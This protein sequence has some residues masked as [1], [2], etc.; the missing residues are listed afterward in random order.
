MK[1]IAQF[2]MITALLCLIIVAL[3]HPRVGVLP[4]NP[5]ATLGIVL[6]GVGLLRNARRSTDAADR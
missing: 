5:M 3:L 6:I 4:G 1:F 2:V